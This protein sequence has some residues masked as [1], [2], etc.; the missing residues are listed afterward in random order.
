MVYAVLLAAGNHRRTGKID[1][2]FYEI[3]GKPLFYYTISTFENN[4]S[5]DKII[6]VGNQSNLNKIG[7]LVERYNFKK[8]ERVIEGGE[9]R[10]ES[11]FKAN[12]FLNSL[13]PSQND[14]ILFHNGA[15]PL[16]SQKEISDIVSNTQNF[17]V[18]IV[19]QKAKDTIKKVDQDGFILKTLSRENI[20]LAQTPQA[21]KFS[22][23]DKAFQKAKEDNF[24]GTDSSSLIERLGN[25]IKIVNASNRNIKVTYPEDFNIIQ[26]YINENFKKN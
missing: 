23:M 17:G 21:M 15:N 7:L 4:S 12:E 2:I 14:I 3:N 19:A 13:N 10:Q 26:S 11:L 5:I 25:K 6:L 16:V 24:I 18:A 8:I 20:Y 9:T 1:K 22:I